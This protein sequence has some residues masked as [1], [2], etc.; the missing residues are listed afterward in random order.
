MTT[1]DVFVLTL[2]LW[3]VDVPVPIT[4]KDGTDYPTELK[5]L[6]AA[7]EEVKAL[8]M[9]PAVEKAV[10]ECKKKD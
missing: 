6:R 7:F 4:L 9:N 2:A 1:S 5:C 10:A 3:V 8:S